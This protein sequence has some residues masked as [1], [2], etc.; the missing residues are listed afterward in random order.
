MSFD[1]GPELVADLTSDTAKLAQA[2]RRLRPGGGTA[3]YDAIYYACR[4]KL[5]QDQPRHKFRRALIVLS[6]GDDNQSRYDA[7]SGAG[8]GAEG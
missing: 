6:D 4:D 8:N 1:T 5:Q 3:F 7:R 2:V